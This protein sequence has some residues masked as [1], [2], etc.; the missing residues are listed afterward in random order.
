MNKPSHRHVRHT[1]EISLRTVTSSRS[2]HSGDNP[3]ENVT[4]V[5]RAQEQ[6]IESLS[7]S[8]SPLLNVHARVSRSSQSAWSDLDPWPAD[9]RDAWAEEVRKQTQTEETR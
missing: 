5:I 3:D 7:L 1:D 6:R 8:Y 9:R 2:S 4:N